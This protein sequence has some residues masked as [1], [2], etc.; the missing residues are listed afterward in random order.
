MRVSARL[1]CHHAVQLNTHFARAYIP[2]KADDSHTSLSW[3]EDLAAL[4]GR[5]A[6]NGWRVAIR[7]ADLTVLL[8]PD[9][10]SFPLDGRTFAEG[11]DWLASRVK[12]S[13]LDPARLY[14]P[15]HFSIPPLDGPFHVRDQTDDLR[16]LAGCY[17]KAD[18]VLEAIASPLRCWPHHFDLAVQI[19]LEGERSIGVG[20]SPGDDD[21]PQPYFYVSPWPYPEA[22]RLPPLP[23]FAKWHTAGWTGAV[24]LDQDHWTPDEVEQIISFL[25]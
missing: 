1:Q 13:G 23:P 20:M 5:P 22:S 8:I 2:A 21:Y 12:T 25:R 24:I 18:A 19:K 3:R 7:L 17:E 11:L 9:G 4:A 10:G 14:H 6:V 15:L 16:R